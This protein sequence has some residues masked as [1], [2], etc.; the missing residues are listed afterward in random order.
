LV[1]EFKLNHKNHR[2]FNIHNSKQVLKFAFHDLTHN[3][4]YS[5]YVFVLKLGF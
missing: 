1:K 3:L 4:P 5:I 2:Q